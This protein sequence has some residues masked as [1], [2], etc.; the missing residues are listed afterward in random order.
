MADLTFSSGNTLIYD[1]FISFSWSDMTAAAAMDGALRDSFSVFYAPRDLPPELQRQARFQFAT[2]LMDALARSAHGVALLSPRYLASA[3]CQLEMRGFFNLHRDD[4]ER[5][6]WLYELEPSGPAVPAALRDL[7]HT[8]PLSAFAAAV[9][10][11]VARSPRRRGYS[12]AGPPPTPLPSLPLHQLYPMPRLAPWAP[13]GKSRG[14]PAGPPYSVYESLVREAMV[15]RLRRGEIDPFA[16]SMTVEKPWL[17]VP[18][19]TTDP[20]LEARLTARALD[21][22]NLLLSRRISPFA[23]RRPYSEICAEL[24]VQ[25]GTNGETPWLLR[26]MA[27]C[28]AHM[29]PDSCREAITLARRAA[30]AGEDPLALRRW[31]ALA[32]YLLGD[33]ARAAALYN[34]PADEPRTFEWRLL[35]AARARQGDTVGAAEAL[36][37]ANRLHPTIDLAEER[38]QT[39]LEQDDDIEHWIGGL[40][41]ANAALN[42]DGSEP[43][44]H[45]PPW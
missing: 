17:A 22:A 25:A 15:Q 3:W 2:P 21:D 18:F 42:R 29:G 34:P 24:M 7:L 8:G 40:R 13:D 4:R 19:D 10:Q 37:Q 28:R 32:H 5:R 41:E 1:V 20:R 30:T 11:N 16:T 14:H 23:K 39:M 31:Q 43:D 33:D 44:P 26:A 6:L 38:L 45:R 27:E 36:R 12:F 9:R 35:A